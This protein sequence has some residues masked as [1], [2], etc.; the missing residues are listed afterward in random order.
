MSL[1]LR[2][3]FEHRGLLVLHVAK[4]WMLASKL[5]YKRHRHDEGLVVPGARS[6]DEDRPLRSARQ[7]SVIGAIVFKRT[8]FLGWNGDESVGRQP[9][10]MV[11]ILHR[12]L[13]VLALNAEND[14]RLLA[15][16]GLANNIEA[17]QPLICREKVILAGPLR[18]DDAVRAATV[19]PLYFVCQVFVVNSLRMSVWRSNDDEDAAKRLIRGRA[20][21]RRNRCSGQR[22]KKAAPGNWLVSVV[23]IARS[24]SH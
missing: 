12:F 16:R 20:S 3:P 11:Q 15:L 14:G 22:C 24:S 18:P 13:P 19:E 10:D 17:A 4:I 7:R 1:Q 2:H 6:L 5:A 9:L 21:I 23:N 8:S